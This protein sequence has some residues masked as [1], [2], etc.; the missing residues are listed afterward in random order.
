MGTPGEIYERPANE[1]VATFVGT[2][3]LI[4]RDGQTYTVRPEKIRL[5]GEAEGDPAALAGTVQEVAYLGSV[6]RYDIALDDGEKIVV[7]RQNLDTSAAQALAQQ[8]RRVSVAWRPQDASQ[9]HTNQEE[10]QSR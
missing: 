1:F 8:G 2:S 5:L 4:R 9:L 7:V 3:N 6:T 10:E